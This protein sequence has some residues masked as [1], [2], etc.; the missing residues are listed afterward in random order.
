MK[1]SFDHLVHFLHRPPLEASDRL[2]KAGFHT[3]AGGRHEMWGTYNSLSYF[4]LSYVEFL[5]VEFPDIA[6]NAENPLVRQL[7]AEATIGEGMGQLAFRTDEIERWAER[8]E[9]RGYRVTGPLPGSRKRE[10]GTLI[11]WKMLFAEGS[12]SKRRIPFLIQWEELDEARVNDLTRRR[13][14]APHENGSQEI[15]CIA[16]ATGNLDEAA[17]DWR[18]WLGL[19]AGEAFADERLQAKCRLIH[20]GGADLLLCQPMGAGIARDAL[21][22][23]GERP[24]LIR[25]EGFGPVVHSEGIFGGVYEWTSRE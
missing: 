24:F 6:A 19:E 11:E 8:F 15:S 14:I 9:Q 25:F 4:G 2:K 23:R 13:I 1:L 10:D 22:T 7:I 20:C 21:S 17:R 5:A 12:E 3:V 18:A 16:L